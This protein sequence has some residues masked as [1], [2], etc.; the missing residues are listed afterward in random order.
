MNG[1]ERRRD[2]TLGLRPVHE[3]HEGN[4]V[5][6]FDHIDGPEP[7]GD[8]EDGVVPDLE[9]GSQRCSDRARM[10]DDGDRH[11]RVLADDPVEGAADSLLQVLVAFAAR[12]ARACGRVQE[13]LLEL[14]RKLVE[15][16]S[17]D[18]P[19][20]DLAQVLDLHRL[21]TVLPGDGR[22]G[23]DGTAERT[24]VDGGELERAERLRK[25]ARLTGLRR[26][27]MATEHE[28]RHDR[29][30]ATTRARVSLTSVAAPRQSPVAPPS[31][32]REKSPRTIVE[33]ATAATIASPCILATTSAPPTATATPAGAA[34]HVTR[35]LRTLPGPPSAR[36]YG[37]T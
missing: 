21:Q 20:I 26:V 23:V 2:P 7:L 15:V 12:K 25:D 35:P 16:A 18:F 3:P 8:A 36:G 14:G 5:E 19:E 4:A 10:T 22:R 30:A 13:R 33:Q 31:Q 17:V 34:G 9:P 32:R 29:A 37:S 1:A 11:T 24:R 28:C 27:G 6:A